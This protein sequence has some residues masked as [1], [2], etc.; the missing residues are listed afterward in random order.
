MPSSCVV[1]C[2]ATIVFY[3]H[4][5]CCIEKDSTAKF[6]LC[7]FYESAPAGTLILILKLFFVSDTA[8]SDFPDA[9]SFKNIF[10]NKLKPKPF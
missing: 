5:I 6:Q 2:S 4:S 8:D 10:A 1:H 9:H 7:F 3:I